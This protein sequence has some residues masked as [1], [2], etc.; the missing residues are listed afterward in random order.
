MGIENRRQGNE[1]SMATTKSQTSSLNDGSLPL[2]QVSDLTSSHQQVISLLSGFFLSFSLLSTS[3]SGGKGSRHSTTRDRSQTNDDCGIGGSVA[4]ATGAEDF[5][6]LQVFSELG[7]E[8]VTPSMAALEV[9]AT[10]EPI[11]PHLA[12]CIVDTVL[13]LVVDRGIAGLEKYID[14]RSMKWC[15]Q[16]LLEGRA[17]LED[18]CRSV[19]EIS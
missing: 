9:V 4:P 15:A 12:A 14:D 2:R 1:R 16:K 18:P 17:H 6:V 11:H 5:I 19:H 10:E 8:M 7:C 13:D 3:D